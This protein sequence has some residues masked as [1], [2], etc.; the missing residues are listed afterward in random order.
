MS[1]DQNWYLPPPPLPSGVWDTPS[2]AMVREKVNRIRNWLQNHIYR[3]TTDPRI[4]TICYYYLELLHPGNTINTHF[5]IY[6]LT[7]LLL[8]DVINEATYNYELN[9]IINTVLITL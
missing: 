1:T 2:Q 5:V 8:L 4:R 6:M 9:H 7:S 3:A